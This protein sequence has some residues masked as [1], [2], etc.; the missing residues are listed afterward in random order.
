MKVL[1][2]CLWMKEMN[3]CITECPI[4]ILCNGTSFTDKLVL[5]LDPSSMGTVSSSQKLAHWSFTD[6]YVACSFVKTLSSMN[7]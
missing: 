2:K 5:Q 4:N 1:K 7:N 6:V 3:K